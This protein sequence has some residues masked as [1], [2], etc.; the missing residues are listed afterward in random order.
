MGVITAI[1]AGL[2]ASI[3]GGSNFNIVG[4]TGALSGI[5]ATFAITHGV[6]SLPMLAII[7]G[8]VILVA[9]AAK[10]EKFIVFIP[11]S[12]VHGFTL[13]VA[14]IIALNQFNFALGLQGLTAHPEFIHNVIES[15]SAVAQIQWQTF[16]IFVVGFI[17]LLF[18]AKKFPKIPGAIVLALIG[19]ALGY[20]SSMG[21]L[22]FQLQTLATK[23]GDIPSSVA[24]FPNLALSGIS[25]ELVI[26]SLT[27]ALVAIL[28]TLIS[29]K[30]ADGM[31]RTKS[32]QRKEVFGL[33]LA[34]IA[35]GLM[36]GIP[37][38]AALARTSLNVKA[39]ADH[40]MSAFISSVSVGLIALLFLSTFKFLPLTIIASI[41]V[42]V[43][44]RMIEAEHFIHLFK[45]DK[46]SFGLSIFVAAVTIVEDPIVGILIGAAIA[47]LI[48]VRKLS[49]A[50]SEVTISKDGKFVERIHTNT[51]KEFEELG[52]T[53]IYRFA[54]QLT[55]INGL[56]HLEILE[57]IGA[58]TKDIVLSFR[59][60]F[61]IDIDGIDMLE[62]AVDELHRQGKRV[63]FTSIN[64][65]VEP[66][67]A[68]MSSYKK[69]L[70]NKMIFSSSQE[71][72]EQL[73]AQ[74]K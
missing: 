41:L 39:G 32:N 73:R 61:F 14:F 16:L 3:F 38:T 19:L 66:L 1:W 71:A 47:L 23:F 12:V 67:L 59:N 34:N 57:H 2:L 20:A 31:T 44:Y 72:V 62:E 5:L 52:D 69:L 27:I 65:A 17:F 68:N 13:G 40:K 8:V 48:I 51:I 7:S 49:L 70:E 56:N 22:P 42:F 33:G 29:A 43:A 26:T 9:Y 6:E 36:G 55:Y 25:K 45:H 53:V 11:A 15:F 37:A 10:F 54:G 30:I 63:C 46:L 24:T 35:S 64:A 21:M 4:P 28:E 18:I 50:H 58:K 74:R 60:L